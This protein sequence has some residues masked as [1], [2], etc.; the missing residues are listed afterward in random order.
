MKFGSDKVVAERYGVHPATVWRLVAAKKLPPPLKI[1]KCS[2]FDLELC[3]E[4]LLEQQDASTREILEALR[5][6]KAAA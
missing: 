1:N 2:R 4:M 6:R 3:D 5:S